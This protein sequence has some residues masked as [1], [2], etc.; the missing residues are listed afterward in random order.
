MDED[1]CLTCA[2]IEA[3]ICAIF[4]EITAG[5]CR[6]MVVKEGGIEFDYSG[7]GRSKAGVLQT[8]RE[9][10]KIKCSGAGSLYE[11]VSVPCVKPATC[12]GD[13]CGSRRIRQ[14]TGRRYR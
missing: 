1:G 13:R 10:Y 4:D 2:E 12:V 14:S 3:K 11:Y 8:L 6:D 5:S 7:T 9:M